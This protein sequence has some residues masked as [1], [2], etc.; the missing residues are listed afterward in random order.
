ME[1]QLLRISFVV[2]VVLLFNFI[3]KKIFTPKYHDPV[4]VSDSDPEMSKAMVDAKNNINE[5]LDIFNEKGEDPQVKIPFITSSGNKEYLWAQL[6]EINDGMLK[7]FLL[8]PPVTH[9]GEIDRNQ[10]Y[11][12]E[13]VVDWCIIPLGYKKRKGGYTMRVMF[14]TVR[15]KNNGVLPKSLKKLEKEINL[16]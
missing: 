1:N 12:L 4:W 5:F 2:L 14:K 9:D 8:T 10:T 3:I 13:D 7:V 6:I 11:K 16:D 15:S